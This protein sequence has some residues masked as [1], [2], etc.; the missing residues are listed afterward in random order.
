MYRTD[1]LVYD[2]AGLEEDFKRMR[3]GLTIN[4]DEALEYS[5]QSGIQTPTVISIRLDFS[6]PCPLRD[7][8]GHRHK[9]SETPE[10]LAPITACKGPYHDAMNSRLYLFAMSMKIGPLFPRAMRVFCH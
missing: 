3:A 5:G 8:S 6:G 4:S 1:R 10:L 7:S 9:R 2:S